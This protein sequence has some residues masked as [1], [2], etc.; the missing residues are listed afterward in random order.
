MKDTCETCLGEGKINKK[1]FHPYYGETAKSQ[2]VWVEEVCP[3]CKG[4]GKKQPKEEVVEVKEESG[5]RP[6]IVDELPLAH[7]IERVDYWS[8]K[9]QITTHHTIF[10]TLQEA[11]RQAW[12]D[13]MN[14]EVYPVR[15]IITHGW[16]YNDYG[17]PLYEAEVDIGEDT[18]NAF[19]RA[20][21]DMIQVA[22][23]ALEE[24]FRSWYKF[25]R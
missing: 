9:P 24:T 12:D 14:G 5:T 23:A 25:G 17:Q 6:P 10:K 15:I 2:E 19:L 8:E 13:Y 20:Y 11:L 7:D 22:P 4:S 21:E 1:M 16:D 3:D 18:L